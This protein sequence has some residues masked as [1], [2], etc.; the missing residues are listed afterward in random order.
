ML[1]QR[2]RG[3]IIV[4]GTGAAAYRGDVGI[5]GGRIVALGRVDESA[6]H[7]LALYQALR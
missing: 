4:D 1:D 3:A 5:E 7:T 2:I 6:R